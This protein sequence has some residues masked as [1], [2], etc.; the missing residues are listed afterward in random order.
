MK[1]ISKNSFTKKLS[2]ATGATFVTMALF[3]GFSSVEA[4]PKICNFTRSLDL[5]LVGEDVRC[6]QQYLNASGSIVSTNGV[7]SPG[8][9]TNQYQAKTKQ[10]VMDWQ[11]KNG[12][13][14]ASGFFG[15][16]SRA[17]YS[18]MVSGSATA[19]IP[20]SNPVTI[21]PTTTNSNSS[22]GISLLLQ[23]IEKL[24]GELAE[25]KSNSNDSNSSGSLK[26]EEKFRNEFR[27]VVRMIDDA[28]DQLEDSNLSDADQRSVEDDIEDAKSAIYEAVTQFFKKDYDDALEEL[29]KAKDDAEDAFADAGGQ[30]DEDE[31]E[32]RLEDL[33]DDLDE[34]REEVEDADDEGKDIDDIEDMLD[35]AED[36]LD[37]AEDAI[38]DKDYD[39]AEDLLD[40]AEDLI[41]EALDELDE[42][43][44]ED[45]KDD[46]KDAIDDADDKIDSVRDK[47]EDADDDGEDVDDAEDL[48]DDAEDKLDDARDEYRDGDYDR[49]EK[50]AKDAE[51]LAEEAED[52]L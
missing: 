3:I 16:V 24:K 7:G 37:E 33:E 51:E 11:R 18:A 50:L 52:E 26:D 19:T 14:P 30:T 2:Y 43:D 27:E 25:A 44:E 46:A 49:A 1:H 36:L 47:I 8:R 21:V 17:R 15:P 13:S 28:E 23:E 34:A 10:A 38:D 31:L 22:V 35:D 12:V 39:D 9:E 45:A 5:G 48:L 32:D 41:D 40:D 6:L 4:A 42:A 29:I 20:V